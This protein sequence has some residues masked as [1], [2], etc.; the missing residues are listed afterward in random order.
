MTAIILLLSI[1][2]DRIS[3]AILVLEAAKLIEVERFCASKGIEA[4]YLIDAERV[5]IVAGLDISEDRPSDLKAS[6][7]TYMKSD[8]SGSSVRLS[9]A[10]RVAIWFAVASREIY[11][12]TF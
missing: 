10:E 3:G 7:E 8:R 4:T 12:R 1:L 5:S 11:D 9:R 2:T 6:L